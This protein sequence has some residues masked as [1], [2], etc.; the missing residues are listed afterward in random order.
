MMTSSPATLIL[1]LGL[2][3]IGLVYPFV[4]LWRLNRQLG[5]A[6]APANRQL[7]VTLALTALVPLTAV[8]AGFWLLV[9]AARSSLL[10][11]GALFGSGIG[12][13]AVLLLGWWIS[14]E[15]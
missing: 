10:F 1:G 5:G 3:V 13:V 12:L 2:I 7:A 6:E 15:K 4:V 14:R 11:T 9:P 8:L